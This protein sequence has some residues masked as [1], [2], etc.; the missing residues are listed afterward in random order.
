MKIPRKATFQDRVGAVGDDC[1]FID[2]IFWF[3]LLFSSPIK[4][5][6]DFTDQLVHPEYPIA[7]PCH[8]T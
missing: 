3:G 1:L 6:E 4:P 2:N 8:A 7:I 5:P